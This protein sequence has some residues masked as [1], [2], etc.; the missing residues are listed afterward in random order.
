MLFNAK[1]VQFDTQEIYQTILD[2]EHYCFDADSIIREGILG[3][4]VQ[5]S[6]GLASITFPTDKKEHDQ[7][8]KMAGE[9]KDSA[10]AR[11]TQFSVFQIIAECSLPNFDDSGLINMESGF[12]KHVLY[13]SLDIN[14]NK[15][16]SSTHKAIIWEVNKLAKEISNTYFDGGW[17]IVLKSVNEI[18]R[19]ITSEKFWKIIEKALIGIKE[20]LSKGIVN[21]PSIAYEALDDVLA[22]NIIKLV[23][24]GTDV[25]E[26]LYTGKCEG[27]IYEALVSKGL[28]NVIL[29]EK[30]HSILKGCDDP[31]FSAIH[32]DHIKSAVRL[33]IKSELVL[34]KEV[35]NIKCTYLVSRM[36]TNMESMKTLKALAESELQ[37]V[38]KMQSDLEKAENNP[39]DSD[40]VKEI[41]SKTEIE[42]E[43]PYDEIRYKYI[44]DLSVAKDDTLIKIIVPFGM[45]LSN[46]FKAKYI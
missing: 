3:Y 18:D 32:T 24:K 21:I 35:S 11:M 20:N 25:P 39:K 34:S 22:L 5:A 10:L 31:Y 6:L 8:I 45:D 17:R 30:K 7:I 33:L 38:E 37:Q 12:Q 23:K 13:L 26:H 14:R 41:N 46:S 28:N 2:S 29:G 44:Y 4:P 9:S 36:F 42:I 43:N 16:L 15:L 1:N 40:T 27:I 19:Y